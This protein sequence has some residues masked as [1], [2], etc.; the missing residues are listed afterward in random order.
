MLMDESC[1]MLKTPAMALLCHVYKKVIYDYLVI[2]T[3]LES[4]FTLRLLVKHK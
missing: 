3:Q 4:L 2:R 1:S